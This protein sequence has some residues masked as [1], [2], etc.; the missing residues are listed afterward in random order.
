MGNFFSRQQAWVADVKN[1]SK[2]REKQIEKAM[3]QKAILKERAEQFSKLCTWTEEMEAEYQA[4]ENDCHVN[5]DSNSLL[6][7]PVPV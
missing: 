2:E 3:A 4:Y 6:A 1:R 5:F 7:T